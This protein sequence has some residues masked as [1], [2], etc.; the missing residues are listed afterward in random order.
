LFTEQLY[1]GDFLQEVQRDGGDVVRQNNVFYRPLFLQLLL[2]RE[3]ETFQP[4]VTL[5]MHDGFRFEVLEQLFIQSVWPRHEEKGYLY[6][7]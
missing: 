6:E 5:L 7:R 3:C 2:E 1:A 4:V